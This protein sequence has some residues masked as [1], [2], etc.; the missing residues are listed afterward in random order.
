MDHTSPATHYTPEDLLA[1]LERLGIGATT[2]HHPPL[3][4][5][6]ESRDLRGM[7]PGGHCKSLFLRTKEGRFILAVVDEARRVPMGPF[8]RALGMGR[9][10]FG[11]EGELFHHLGIRPGSVTPFGLVHDT[12]R[13]VHVVLDRGMLE[14]NALL[15]YHPL[16]NTMTTAIASA[17]LLRFLAHTGHVPQTVD[18]T[19]LSGGE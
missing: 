1:L 2:H 19:A 7:L 18:F 14:G 3:F 10:S 9:L 16:I 5:V 12:A 13:A 15:N 17:D 11:T 6:D 4:T 8:G